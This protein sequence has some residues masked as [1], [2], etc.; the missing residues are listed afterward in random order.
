VVSRLGPISAV[1]TLLCAC[2]SGLVCLRYVCGMRRIC[3]VCLRMSFRLAPSSRAAVMAP[4]RLEYVEY[5]PGTQPH[6]FAT[7]RM[8]ALTV[9]SDA[10]RNVPLRFVTLLRM[11]DVVGVNGTLAVRSSTPLFG[12]LVS[13]YEVEEF[14]VS[15]VDDL[16]NSM[17]R[18][19]PVDIRRQT[20]ATDGGVC[21]IRSE[22]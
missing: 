13:E 4:W 5:R 19:L 1:D 20:A 3:A 18:T 12:S 10:T 9:A 8:H 7:V 16:V 21:L 15:V 6:F 14:L 22:S 2:A 11:A 17:C